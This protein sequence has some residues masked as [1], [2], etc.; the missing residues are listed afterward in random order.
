MTS[1][2][3]SFARNGTA[4][5]E[6]S[7][8]ATSTGVWLRSAPAR[9]SHV[10]EAGRRLLAINPFAI[11]AGVAL[12][13]ALL[14]MAKNALT[15]TYLFEKNY[16][17]GWN[18]YN[19]QRLING[20]LIYDDNYWRVNNY[21]I[22]SFLIVTDVNL[23]IGDLLLSGRI[24]ALI[25]F[26]AIGVFAASATR[27]LGGRGADA[28]FGAAC[29]LGFCYLVAPGWIVADDP[30][31]L[32]EAAVLAGLVSYLSRPPD[33]LC[34]LRTAFLIVMGGFIKHNLLAIPGAI[35]LDLAVRS[36]R[37]LPFWF[38]CCGG[39]AAGFLGLTQLVGGGAFIDH[40]LSPRIFTWY[41]VRYHLLKY[42]RLFKFPLLAIVL[43]C[44]LAFPAPRFILAAWGASSIV[45]AAIF[46]GFEGASYNMFQD[47]AVF[48]GVAAGVL[49]CELRKAVTIRSRFAKLLA[50]AAALLLA[51]P[52]LTRAPNA[53]LQLS[54]TGAELES[55][56]QAEAT[57]LTDASYIAAR[58]PAICESLLLCYVARQ[59][60]ILDPFN[61]RQYILAG[62][63][64]EAQLITRITAHEFGVI[65]LRGDICDDPATASCHILHYHQKFNRF[66]D[67]TLYAID[68]YYEIGRRSRYGTFYVPK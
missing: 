2:L 53:L 43:G 44:R 20:E 29:A 61:S 6:R 18:I 30:Q 19:A 41:G 12:I 1:R 7:D 5:E 34:L 39:F 36:P 27:R 21:P 49:F 64:D 4:N 59:P 22:G 3:R 55:D 14:L 63:L 28:V 51:Q 65:Q 45:L 57:F 24:V 56:R 62:K 16:N 40:L 68:R 8:E 10:A 42:L 46:S 15:I 37:R 31:T 23:L 32:G 50:G 67:E 48:L 66:T 60:F 33:N 26:V 54:R 38:A 13:F 35:T 11:L 17:E 9:F 58:G 47:A 25:S 52:I